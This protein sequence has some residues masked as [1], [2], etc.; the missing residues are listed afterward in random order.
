MDLRARP[1]AAEDLP[2]LVALQQRFDSRWFGTPEHDEAEVRA[3][4][5]RVDPLAKHSL[6]LHDGDRLLAAAWW[7]KD[8]STL[9][10]EPELD[11]EVVAGEAAER[12][13]RWLTGS[14]THHAEVLAEIAK[15][16]R[17]QVVAVDQDAAGLRPV[18]GHDQAD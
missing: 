5:D 2:A 15:L 8:E 4:F 13:A 3:S 18:E 7:W 1:A 10:L 16:D 6:L 12:L 14:G 11:D 17:G 9:L